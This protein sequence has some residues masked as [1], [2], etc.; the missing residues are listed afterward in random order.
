MAPPNAE[1]Q[2]DDDDNRFIC[3][4]ATICIESVKKYC[5]I[6]AVNIG[7]AAAR[8]VGAAMIASLVAY[9]AVPLC[10]QNHLPQDKAA[11][12]RGHDRE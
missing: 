4:T 8:G 1:W 11:S 12:P 9:P 7:I 10:R 5:M 6:M 3:F 2:I